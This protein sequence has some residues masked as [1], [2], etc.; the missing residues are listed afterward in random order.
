MASYN[1]DGWFY[2][3]FGLLL[4]WFEYPFL[5]NNNFKEPYKGWGMARYVW[6]IFGAALTV[7]GI[8]ILANN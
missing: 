8:Y 4:L 1:F 3:L 7:L 5:T 2:L 6:F